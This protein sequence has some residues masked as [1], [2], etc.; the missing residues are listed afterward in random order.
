MNTSRKKY[1]SLRSTTYVTNIDV[2][3]KS[4]VINF[5]GGNR[6]TNTKGFFVTDDIEEQRALEALPQFNKDFYLEEVYRYEK[7]E[8]PAV[9]PTR[10]VVVP[11]EEQPETATAPV[12]TTEPEAE[13]DAETNSPGEPSDETPSEEQPSQGSNPSFTG[14]TNMTNAKAKLME[15]FPEDGTT[16]AELKKAAEIR[17]FAREKG[18]VFPDWS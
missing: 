6:A 4:K 14:I 13:D 7:A 5:D 2:N 16:I 18:V 17:A 10:E 15:L 12:P 8:N 9:P 3:G 11:A 1:R